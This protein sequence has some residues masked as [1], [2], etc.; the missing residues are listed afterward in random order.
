MCNFLSGEKKTVQKE[1]IV[2]KDY[3]NM[4]MNKTASYGTK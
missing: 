1:L 4:F 3:R 2:T